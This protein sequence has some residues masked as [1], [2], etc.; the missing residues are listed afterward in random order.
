M[1]NDF[2]NHFPQEGGG[3]FLKGKVLSDNPHKLFRVDGEMCIRDRAVWDVPQTPLLGLGIVVLS[4]IPKGNGIEAEVVVQVA[5]VQMGGDDDL[6]LP[7]PHL[8]RQ[9]HADLMAPPIWT[10]E[11]CIRDRFETE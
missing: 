5:F 1:H 3:K 2:F 8:F 6:E 7:A 4:P 10:K 9:F 11:M